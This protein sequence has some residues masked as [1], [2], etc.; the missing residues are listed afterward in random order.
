MD[1][2][3]VGA[4][5]PRNSLVSLSQDSLF[6]ILPMPSLVMNMSSSICVVRSDWIVSLSSFAARA[7][8]SF[9]LTLRSLGTCQQAKAGAIVKQEGGWNAVD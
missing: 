2:F 3:F 1:K 9:L 6:S 5:L 4:E 8:I 7:K